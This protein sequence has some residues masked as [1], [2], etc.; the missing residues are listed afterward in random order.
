MTDTVWSAITPETRIK[1]GDVLMD[2]D[3]NIYAVA[4][5]Y[6]YFS[7]PSLKL[8]HVEKLYDYSIQRT[9]VDTWKLCSSPSLRRE[10]ITVSR[11]FKGLLSKRSLI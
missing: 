5:V 3:G 10:Y 6:S 4:S 1:E 8:R 11:R 9:R 2:T 7:T